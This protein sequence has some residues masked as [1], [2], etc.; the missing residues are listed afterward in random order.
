MTVPGMLF[1]A[2]RGIVK[3]GSPK[4]SALF[5][6]LTWFILGSHYTVTRQ[7]MIE[8]WNGDEMKTSGKVAVSAGAGAIAGAAHGLISYGLIGLIPGTFLYSIYGAGG[9]IAYNYLRDVSIIPERGWGSLKPFKKISSDEYCKRLE[10]KLLMMEA[11]ISI[12]D[13][14]VEA[15]RKRIQERKFQ[16]ENVHR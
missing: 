6:G 8:K 11:E 10:E 1:G 13:D 5:S 3:T 7:A 2:V 4:V 15:A 12:I 16:E 14:K 9:Q